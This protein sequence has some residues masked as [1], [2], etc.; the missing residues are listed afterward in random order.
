M[1]PFSATYKKLDNLSLVKI[2]DTPANYQPEAI[3]AANEELTARQLTDDELTALHEEIAAE[4]HE[5]QLKSEKINALKDK[6]KGALYSVTDSLNPIQSEK[7]SLP[8]A[9][10]W[11][12]ILMILMFLYQ[13]Y[14]QYGLLKYMLTY[15]TAKWDFTMATY[16]IRPLVIMPLAAILFALRKNTGWV[17]LSGY[18]TYL[19]INTI[20]LMYMDFKY[21]A[22][23]HISSSLD[24][25]QSPA[26]SNSLIGW[27]VFIAG[28]LY[29]IYKRDVREIYNVTTKNILTAVA[30]GVLLMLSSMSGWLF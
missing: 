6:A 17:L 14:L 11:L 10:L 24:Q 20:A 19:A 5:Q 4:I 2:I 27:S 1:N 21:R 28:C 30:I 23:P 25:L 29:F 18:L 8:K 15:D 9:I 16:F 7:P 3:E 12:S 26:P 13:L 22:E